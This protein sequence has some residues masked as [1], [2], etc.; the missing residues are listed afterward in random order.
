MTDDPCALCLASSSDDFHSF[1]SQLPESQFLQRCQV[2]LYDRQL[3]FYEQGARYGGQI[4]GSA[5]RGTSGPL[6]Q[7]LGRCAPPFLQWATAAGWCR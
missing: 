1:T 7:L 3:H 5:L 6:R 2:T 4:R